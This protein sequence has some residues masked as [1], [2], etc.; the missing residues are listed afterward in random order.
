M[1][2]TVASP[3]GPLA[4]YACI[5]RQRRQLRKRWVSKVARS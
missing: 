3:A 1:A 4:D 5:E 2:L